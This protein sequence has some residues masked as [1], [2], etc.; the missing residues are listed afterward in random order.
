MTIAIEADIVVLYSSIVNIAPS[1]RP[2]TNLYT[3]LDRHHFHAHAISDGVLWFD[4]IEIAIDE[5]EAF[6]WVLLIMYF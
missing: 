1:Q 4:V 5:I 2:E 3:L 6:H